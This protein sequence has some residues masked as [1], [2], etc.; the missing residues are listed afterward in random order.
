MLVVFAIILAFFVGKRYN[1]IME[2]STTTH[3][4]ALLSDIHGNLPALEALLGYFAEV[5]VDRYINLGDI[6]D[7]GAYS[8]QCLHTMLQ[9]PHCTNILGNHDYDYACDRR[10]HLPMSHTSAQHKAYVFD[11]IGSSYRHIVE[12]FDRCLSIT[13]GGRVFTFVH[14]ALASDTTYGL[15]R[16]LVPHPTAELLDSTFDT[17]VGDV[18]LYGHK[19]EPSHFVGK[20]VYYDVGSVGC[21]RHSVARGALLQLHSDGSYS[22]T[23]VSVSYDRD[24][25]RQDMTNGTLPDGK[26]LFDFYLDRLGSKEI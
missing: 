13:H 7:I 5:G 12:Q 2:N 19:H 6:V 21:H 22:Y 16:Q 1:N 8:A 20:K 18:I 24:S 9:L 25:Y 26:Q 3:T 11:S 23:P 17:T 14:Y 4:I 10:R 15:F